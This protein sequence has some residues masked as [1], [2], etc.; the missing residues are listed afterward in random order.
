MNKESRRTATSKDVDDVLNEVLTGAESQ[1]GYMYREQTS[2]DNERFVLS[3]LAK[4]ITKSGKPTASI[5][6]IRKILYKNGFDVSE[7]ELEER[8]DRLTKNQLLMR[9]EREASF[10]FAVDLLRL[11]INNNMPI[12]R[13]A[14]K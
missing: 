6:E 7:G 2:S 1:I 14:K 5:P 13:V 10:R 3:A 9:N 12:E 8:M 4:V 11:W